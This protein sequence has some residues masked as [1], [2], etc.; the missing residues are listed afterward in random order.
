M[1]TVLFFWIGFS[2][3][4]AVAAGA[5]GRTGILWFFLS[6]LVSPLI[7]LLLVLFLERKNVPRAA[8]PP[9]IPDTAFEPDSVYAGIPYRLS[10]DGSIEAVIQGAR[11]W[12]SDYQKFAAV[13][14]APRLPSMPSPADRDRAKGQTVASA[15]A[16]LARLGQSS[17][18]EGAS[19]WASWARQREVP[20]PP[21]HRQRCKQPPT[22]SKSCRLWTTG[23]QPRPD[24]FP[25]P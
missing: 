7:A 12:F 25:R 19:A 17:A 11:M 9:S 20:S 18:S 3:V 22:S 8:P 15:C 23:F 13:I 14:G 21:R 6:L 5:R 16:S 1:G 24:R 10:P 4:G 2:I